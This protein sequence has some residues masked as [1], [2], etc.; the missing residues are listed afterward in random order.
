[1]KNCREISEMVIRSREE[2]LRLRD[3]L[4]LKMHLMIC[5]VCAR[6][7][8]QM[9]W[10]EQSLQALRKKEDSAPENA[11]YKLSDEARERISQQLKGNA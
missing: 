1:V 8:R 3:R 2:K 5:A 11:E 9:K 4:E 10:L 7:E 6:Y